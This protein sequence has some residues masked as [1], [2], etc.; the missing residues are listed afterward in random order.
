MPKKFGTARDH[1]L[2][3]LQRHADREITTAELFDLQPPGGHISKENIFNLMPKLEREGV[4]CR[5][6][7]GRWCWW[8]ITEKG[9]LAK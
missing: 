1:V 2:S 7:E 8:A 4:I 9:L 6:A 3:T 5:T